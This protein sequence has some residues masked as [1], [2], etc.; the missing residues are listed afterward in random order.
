VNAQTLM[1]IVSLT[2]ASLVLAMGVI[3]LSGFLIPEYVPAN[4]RIIMGC[5]LVL[6]SLYRMATLWMKRRRPQDTDQ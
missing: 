1:F 6:Y 2:T 4:F 3:V 5:V